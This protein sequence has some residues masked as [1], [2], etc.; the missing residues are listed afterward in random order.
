M[1]ETAQKIQTW[2]LCILYNQYGYQNTISFIQNIIRLAPCLFY[3]RDD[4]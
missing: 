1:Q 2:K 3:V 4:P